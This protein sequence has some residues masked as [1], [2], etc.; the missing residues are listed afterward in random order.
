MRRMRAGFWSYLWFGVPALAAAVAGYGI[1]SKARNNSVIATV[2]S[3]GLKSGE[4]LHAAG[5]GRA[6]G[7]KGAK[8]SKNGARAPASFMEKFGSKLGS[9]SKKDETDSI[10][11]SPSIPIGKGAAFEE[12]ESD[13]YVGTGYAV[14]PGPAARSLAAAEV[15]QVAG[16][17]CDR[18]ELR[19]ASPEAVRVNKKDWNR[20][21][22]AFHASKR[23][24]TSWLTSQDFPKPIADVMLARVNDL[25][26]QRPSSIEEP[27]LS[28][29]GIAIYTSSAESPLIRVG[30]GFVK[31]MLASTDL[32]K[33]EMTRLVAQTWAPCELEKQ[34]I[35]SI[36]SPLLKCL[37]SNVESCRD[38]TNSE[39]G[40][41]VSTSV[42]FAVHPPG[43]HCTLPAF[44]DPKTAS[45]LS[46]W[47]PLA[48]ARVVKS[49]RAVAS[50]P[51]A[52]DEVPSST[53]GKK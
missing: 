21:M 36:W 35:S 39:S 51:W 6:K 48:S 4:G 49:A 16:N 53:H 33:F 28:W 29:R 19:G 8:D 24:L 13:E 5:H 15:G 18:S 44:S 3:S 26:I 20:V 11:K 42:A 38:G 40:W 23:E 34:K 14:T 27:D 37:G 31:R 50:E 22:D 7:L 25:K 10:G 17:T 32:A 43:L 41:A 30:T 52:T 1:Y 45:C 9:L 47:K 46:A 2:P 12:S